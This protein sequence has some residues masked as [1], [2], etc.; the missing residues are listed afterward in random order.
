MQLPFY[1]FSHH[2]YFKKWKGHCLSNLQC[3]L[4]YQN[5]LSSAKINIKA[6][7]KESISKI[8]VLHIL[9]YLAFPPP[10][11]AYENIW[12]TRHWYSKHFVIWV[13]EFWG[14]NLFVIH[15]QQLFQL[16]VGP[17]LR[18]KVKLFRLAHC[19]TYYL[20]HNAV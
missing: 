3:D 14:N 13:W 10:T 18:V 7:S 20:G 11:I 19:L 12:T 4:L 2:E 6:N 8:N 9:Q 15:M 17:P 1:P 16:S 5:R